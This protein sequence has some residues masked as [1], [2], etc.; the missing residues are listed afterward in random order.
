MLKCVLPSII[1]DNQSVFVPSCLITDNILLS[2]KVFH[3]MN[4]N[5]AKK[6]GYMA[7]KLDMSKAYDRMEWDFLACVM[8]KLGFPSHWIDCVMACVT[9]VSYSFVVNGE[10]TD[11]WIP[12]R[13]L[14][15]GDPISPYLF[16]L[17]FEGLG[18][19]IKRAILHWS[20]HGISIARN[21]PKISHFVFCR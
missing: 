1:D 5:H 14:R 18:A 8:A 17:Y 7:L 6:R 19:L 20:L 21:A 12:S 13:G 15:Q 2:S 9:S 16:L 10:L 4:H 3:F 11:V